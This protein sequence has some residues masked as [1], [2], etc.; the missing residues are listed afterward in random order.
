MQWFY[1]RFI[2]GG[3]G[4][5]IWSDKILDGYVRSLPIR[6]PN[7]EQEVCIPQ[8]P[9]ACP[10]AESR[11]RGCWNPV[12]RRSGPGI[13]QMPMRS[14][15]SQHLRRLVDGSWDLAV[16]FKTTVYGL[17]ALFCGIPG[18]R[19]CFW[20]RFWTPVCWRTNAG[21]CNYPTRG[22]GNCRMPFYAHRPSR[23]LVF[24]GLL[25]YQDHAGSS[26]S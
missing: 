23:S 18:H 15:V 24:F 6:G 11:I 5:V 19:S 21:G 1:R 12:L 8:L 22:F 9:K 25:R 14:H 16:C 2:D 20:R 7:V 3:E 10:S 4:C 13:W 17:L 26:C